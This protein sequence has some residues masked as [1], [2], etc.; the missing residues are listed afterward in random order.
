[1]GFVRTEVAL[2]FVAPSDEI[3]FIT[4]A[5]KKYLVNAHEDVH[6][7]VLALVL[8]LSFTR[9]YETTGRCTSMASLVVGDIRH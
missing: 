2:D 1:M 6:Y 8:A 9:H 4:V 5:I 7:K 3:N